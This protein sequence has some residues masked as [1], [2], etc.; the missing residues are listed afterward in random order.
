MYPTLIQ[1]QTATII[2]TLD[3]FLVKPGMFTYKHKTY[4]KN[5]DKLG[6]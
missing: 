3:R 4:V 6:I 1:E 5:W 2:S